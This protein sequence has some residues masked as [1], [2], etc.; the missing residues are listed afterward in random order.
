MLMNLVQNEIPY[1]NSIQ[2][3]YRSLSNQPKNISYS[4]RSPPRVEADFFRRIPTFPATMVWREVAKT[5]GIG[6]KRQETAGNGGKRREMAGHWGTLRDIEGHWGTLREIREVGVI[7]LVVGELVEGDTTHTVLI[8]FLVWSWTVLDM[9]PWAV[10]EEVIIL[11]ND[12]TIFKSGMSSCGCSAYVND[13]SPHPL[14]SFRKNVWFE[15]I[16]CTAIL[17][18]PKIKFVTI[19]LC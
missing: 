12:H 5:A 7:K 3:F 11:E 6:G 16:K 8:N 4:M 14:V 2:M 13:Q 1:P 15:K 9:L 10:A 18:L 17:E 19:C